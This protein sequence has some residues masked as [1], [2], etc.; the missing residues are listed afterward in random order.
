MPDKNQ[1]PISHG[2]NVPIARECREVSVHY[3][4][5]MSFGCSK[6]GAK[7]FRAEQKAQHPS[8]FLDCCNS[9]RFNLDVFEDFPADLRL[10]FV[11]DSNNTPEIQRL[12]INFLEFIR[13]FNSSFAMASMGAQ[14]D[15][16]RGVGPY[17]FRI[18]GQVYHNIGPLH[19]SDGQP[20]RF[21]Q[22][23]ILDT[24]EAA[25]QRSRLPQNNRCDPLL[26][27]SLSRLMFQLNPYAQSFRMMLELEQAEHRDA[28]R[29]NRLPV[30]LRMVFSNDRPSG[31][32]GRLYDLPTANEVA[33]V[34][35][36][37]E[38]D[39]PETRAI[40]VHSRATDRTLINI[41]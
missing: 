26:I 13:N 37:D 12:H 14:I 25:N 19:P 1:I 18:H 40:A 31:L 9:G 22:L 2:A 3:A 34:Y 33:V 28:Q 35:V 4:G 24:A 21:G 41:S 15:T 10:F 29:E 32:P 23:Y 16:P 36:G 20:R 8:T 7:H 11:R 17:C 39:V 5:P 27:E 6:C 38:G 30:N